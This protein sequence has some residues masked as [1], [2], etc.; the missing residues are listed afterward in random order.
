[1]ANP[2]RCARGV[3]GASWERA[4]DQ[5][6][7]AHG[8]S[9]GRRKSSRRSTTVNAYTAERVAEFHRQEL[10]TAAARARLVREASS[11]VPAKPARGPV[12]PLFGYVRYALT[13]LA[14]VAFGFNAGM[15]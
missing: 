11:T 3:S 15:N 14:S 7:T 13:S 1:M 8:Q 2:W 4:Q 9:R 5:T 6:G 12:A 10:L